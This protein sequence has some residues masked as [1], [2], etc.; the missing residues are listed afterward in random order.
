MAKNHPLTSKKGK[1]ILGFAYGWGASVVIVGALFKILHWPGANQMLMVGLGTE[2]IIFFISAF[3]PPHMD[4]DWAKV[5][6]ELSDGEGGNKSITKSL[7]DLLEESNIEQ[8]MLN[9]LGENMGKLSDNVSKMGDMGD[10]V[11][12]TS[13]FSSNAKGASE[14]LSELKHAYQGASESAHSMSTGMNAFNET[15]QSTSGVGEFADN[16][17]MA[18]QAMGE[19]SQAYQA[20]IAA[21]SELNSG[22]AD[23]SSGLQNSMSTLSNSMD[24]LNSIADDAESI[25][26]QMSHLSSNLTSLNEVYGNMLNAMRPS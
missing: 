7:D 6:P 17:K 24:S 16:A 11:N 14:A 3:E 15:M 20:S 22:I 25:K 26:T 1:V 8:D 12:S 23:A 13:E 2:A 18:A 9:R 21:A 4:L 10:V 19:L 5:Y